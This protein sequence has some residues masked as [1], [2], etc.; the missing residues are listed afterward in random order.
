MSDEQIDAL[1]HGSPLPDATPLLQAAMATVDAVIDHRPIPDDVH[2]VVV[3]AT[4]HEGILEMVT[5]CGFYR[6]IAGI[7]VAFDM[8][9]PDTPATDG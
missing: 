8:V 9:V 1:R 5:L 3:D 4:G 2:H 7:I 6:L